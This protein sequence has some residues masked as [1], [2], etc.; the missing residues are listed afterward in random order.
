M[1]GDIGAFPTGTPALDISNLQ[2]AANALG[3]GNAA[4]SLVALLTASAITVGAWNPALTPGAS[5]TITLDAANSY[6]QYFRIADWCWILARVRVSAIAAP[7][8]AVSLTGLPFA[9]KAG[10][11]VY[12]VTTRGNNFAGAITPLVNAVIV[13]AAQ[14]VT[15]LKSG[16]AADAALAGG[17]VIVGTDI[18]LAGF[19]RTV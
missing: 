12:P 7:L 10:N 15:L 18:V 3:N 13:A 14:A 8:G 9:A 19:Y 17:D 5:G 11:G 1:A 4:Q 16:G 6:G 2:I